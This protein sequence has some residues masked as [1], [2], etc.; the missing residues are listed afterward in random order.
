MF[1]HQRPM[2]KEQACQRALTQRQTPGRWFECP[3]SLLERLQGRIA[4]EARGERRGALVS[5]A[6]A[7]LQCPLLTPQKVRSL[8]PPAVDYAD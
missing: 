2:V 1:V 7:Q 3:S 5:D 8:T 4:L 6:R